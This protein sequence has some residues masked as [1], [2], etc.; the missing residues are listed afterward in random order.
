MSPGSRP[1]TR[2]KC[3]STAAYSSGERL[4]GRSSGMFELICSKRCPTGSAIHVMEKIGPLNSFAPWHAEQTSE[5][6][7]WPRSACSDVK[8]AG[9]IAFDAAP[10]VS[11]VAAGTPEVDGPGEAHA[12]RPPKMI[13]L[14]VA[15]RIIGAQ[16]GGRSESDR[17]PLF[18]IRTG[19]S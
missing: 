14:V 10:R 7:R 2:R 18:V 6:T 8:T 4:P 19:T 1:F 17:P 3:A 11:M 5:K 13:T 16:K 15:R 9:V 12:A